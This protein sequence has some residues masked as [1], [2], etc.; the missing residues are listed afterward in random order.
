MLTKTICYHKSFLQIDEAKN[1]ESEFQFLV[2]AC[3]LMITNVPPQ[4]ALSIQTNRV[5]KGN[6]FVSMCTETAGQ[7]TEHTQT[8]IP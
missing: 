7:I 4:E 6:C 2:Y 5:N 1:M 8:L 3:L